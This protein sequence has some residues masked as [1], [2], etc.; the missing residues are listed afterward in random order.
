MRQ[1]SGQWG[2]CAW[3]RTQEHWRPIYFIY[4]VY[5]Q[6]LAN[7]NRPQ[8]FHFTLTRVLLRRSS[9][10]HHSISTPAPLS[11]FKKNHWAHAHST[12]PSHSLHC[13]EAS[14]MQLCFQPDSQWFSFNLVFYQSTGVHVFISE[15]LREKHLDAPPTP[16]PI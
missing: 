16:G 1:E 10:P 12:N 15:I 9:L 13:K 8:Q 2:S 11:F 7:T 14:W 3:T 4:F 5:R 6:H